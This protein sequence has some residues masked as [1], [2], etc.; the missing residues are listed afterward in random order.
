[1]SDPVGMGQA[2]PTV[3]LAKRDEAEALAALIREAFQT[4]ADV[5][6]DIP[7]LHETAADLEAT[8]DA[9]D[10]TLVAEIEGSVVGTVRGETMTDNTL[11]VRRLAVLPHAR[12]LGV[13]RAL[14]VA[15]EAHYPYVNRFEL[16]TGDL[17][18]AAIGLYESLGYERIG[19]R[20]VAPGIE[21]VT[22]E[23]LT[24]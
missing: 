23:K 18:K 15:L 2:T 16:F 13:G 8:F 9:G 10:V 24:W 20:E 6:G 5:Y 14:L 4:E 22:L 11:V 17:N 3:R 7:P 19:T 12:G 21:L 1:M